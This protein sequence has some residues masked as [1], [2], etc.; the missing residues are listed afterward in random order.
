MPC[1][2][3]RQRG[4]RVRD[5]LPHMATLL[6]VM[7][8]RLGV[9][10]SLSGSSQPRLTGSATASGRRCL[11]TDTLPRRPSSPLFVFQRQCHLN[12]LV[13][14]SRRPCADG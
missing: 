5:P 12:E 14:P 1:V 10:P 9:H 3:G 7:R 6:R 13:C 4:G 2:P 8:P 11:Q